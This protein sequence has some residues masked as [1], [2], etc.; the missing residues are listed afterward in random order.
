M[1]NQLL[2]VLPGL[3][4]SASSVRAADIVRLAIC[5]P[6]VA[7]RLILLREAYPRADLSVIAVKYPKIL[8]KDATT[9]QQDVE[10]VKQLL[11]ACSDRDRLLQEM[12]MLMDPECLRGVLD[13][14]QR[15]FGKTN[16]AALLLEG[17]PE[18][19]LSCQSLHNQSRG[20]RDADYLRDMLKAW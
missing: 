15:L 3:A 8:L 17:N 9:L 14:L 4:S 6:D 1:V 16:N 5:V 10:Q 20:E 7:Q 12:P 13:E 19:A 2:V 11:E 18:L